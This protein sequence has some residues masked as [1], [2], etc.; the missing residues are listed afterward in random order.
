M[1][2]L[3]AIA[4]VLTSVFLEHSCIAQE[5]SLMTG[6]DLHLQRGLEQYEEDAVKSL[7]A[8]GIHFLVEDEFSVEVEE[9]LKS[10]IL[11]DSME[12]SNGE[13]IIML[14]DDSIYGN[15]EDDFGL[16]QFF[17]QMNHAALQT[18]PGQ[19]LTYQEM[20]YSTFNKLTNVLVDTREGKTGFY[21]ENYVPIY[22]DLQR[23]GLIQELATKIAE[24]RT[25]SILTA[26]ARDNGLFDQ[27]E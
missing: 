12:D 2:R 13:V 18:E 20:V 21:W 23:E 26:Y 16:L 9:K 24:S 17:I 19:K 7:L 10:L 15:A 25:S 27:G 22:I 3:I 5:L 1:N 11:G 6:K 4:F 8:L 14:N